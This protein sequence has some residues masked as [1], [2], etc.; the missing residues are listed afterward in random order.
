MQTINQQEEEQK[1]NIQY[2]GGTDAFPQPKQKESQL[3]EVVEKK[4]LSAN[5]EDAENIDILYV[6]LI[7][8]GF[9]I[10][11]LMLAK[12]VISCCQH[13]KP[14]T[15]TQMLEDQ[16]W[17]VRTTQLTAVHKPAKTNGNSNNLQTISYAE[18]KHRK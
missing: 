12:L 3:L 7:I 16:N 14:K 5:F 17:A 11:L 1:L 15:N 4:K 13:K 9:V 8:I 10:I 6:I 18:S 2:Q